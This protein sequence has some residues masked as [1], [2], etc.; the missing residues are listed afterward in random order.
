MS[1]E[2]QYWFC[3]DVLR[4]SDKRTR[5]SAARRAATE[6]ARRTNPVHS[7]IPGKGTGLPEGAAGPFIDQDLEQIQQTLKADPGSIVIV[8]SEERKNNFL[9]RAL[10]KCRG[11]K[12]GG[13]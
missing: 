5:I 3:R 2:F 8:P 12:P 10:K 11:F 13:K 9:Q 6:K 1:Y 7:E 4:M